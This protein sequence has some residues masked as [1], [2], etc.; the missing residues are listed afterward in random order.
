MVMTRGNKRKFEQQ[1]AAT[2]AA[3]NDQQPTLCI[4]L[5]GFS[6]NPSSS[7]SQHTSHSRVAKRIETCE[8]LADFVLKVSASQSPAVTP[9]ELTPCSTLKSQSKAVSSCPTTTPEPE[10]ENPPSQE[11]AMVRACSLATSG[12]YPVRRVRHVPC[13]RNKSTA[14]IGAI[15]KES[16]DDGVADTFCAGTP[17]SLSLH[18]PVFQALSTQ[19]GE[20]SECIQSSPP[21]SSVPKAVNGNPMFNEHT[22]LREAIMPPI[23]EVPNSPSEADSNARQATSLNLSDMAAMDD[24]CSSFDSVLSDPLVT[25]G[26]YRV[27]EN[28]A[29]ILRD[30]LSKYGDI[31]AQCV[32]KSVL[33]RSW[34]VESVCDIVEKLRTVEFVHLTAVEVD[35]FRVFV[36]DIESDN[37]EVGW[38]HQR[39]D[40]IYEAK[41]LLKESSKVKQAKSQNHHLTKRKEEEIKAYKREIKE[42]E[43][44]ICKRQEKIASANEELEV[45]MAEGKDLNE[46]LSYTKAQ[47][48]RF[49]CGSMIS[50]LI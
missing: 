50:G 18:D 4:T 34:L 40:E 37:V 12:R 5:P 8:K 20:G 46:I 1:E 39:L 13:R 6:S 29:P 28:L 11:L 15:K 24:D 43:E 49:H 30:V 48:K 33:H 21:L 38:L 10:V 31:A 42:Y 45:R 17:L 47:V 44:E 25:V 35:S 14:A 16:S 3:A 36:Q 2:A 22:P 9:S 27:K 7:Y 41:R 19:L 32:K 23:E 26:N